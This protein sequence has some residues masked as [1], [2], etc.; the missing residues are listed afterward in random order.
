MYKLKALLLFTVFAVVAVIFSSCQENPTTT[1]D[2]QPANT[3]EKF[4]LPAG[5][6]IDDATLWV[7]SLNPKGND[8]YAHNI[9]ADWQECT[10]TWNSFAESFNPTV[11]GSFSNV[12]PAGWKS[13][14]ITSLVAGWVDG[15][16]T[17]Y[18]VLLKED[19]TDPGYI[20]LRSQYDSREGANSP[21]LEINYTDGSGTHN[22]T[23]VPI[24]DV[25]V[26]QLNPTTN[27]CY[28]DLLYTGTI[29]ANQK[30][31]SLLKFEFEAAPPEVSCETAYAYDNDPNAVGTCFIDL[32]FGNWGWSIWLPSEGTYEFPVYA[33]AGQCDITKGTYVGTVTVNYSG[34]TANFNYNFEPGFTSDE[35]HFY[36]GSTPTPLKKNGTP[37][38][39]PGSYTIGTGLGSGGIYIIAHAVVCSDSWD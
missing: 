37:T 13:V 27:Y 15:S 35:T 23:D 16:I 33:G 10:V 26:W 18:G 6:T 17:N 25:Y 14:D 11:I 38:V 5:A 39:A 36:A 9:T 21:Y 29:S 8:V 31:Y 2:N 28:D 30:K 7:Y 4:T 32:G 3:L 20:F 19:I 34:G 24:A 12:V 22:V 1:Q